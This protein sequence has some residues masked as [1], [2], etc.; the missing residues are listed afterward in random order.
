VGDTYYVLGNNGYLPGVEAYPKA[1]EAALKALELDESLAEAHASLAA[2]RAEYDRDWSAGEREY[3]RAIG[4]NPSYATAHAWYAW[5]LAV[6]GR[7][8]EAIR[9]IELARR[10]DPLSPR[11]SA[12]VGL[13]LY[14]ARQY[15]RAIAE[16]LK[17]VELEPGNVAA[18]LYL[19]STYLQ[20]GINGEALSEA[21]KAASLWH[22]PRALFS[23]A[24]VYAVTGKRD[25][26]LKKLGDL[27]E[28]SKR[29]HVSPYLIAIVSVALGHTNEAFA[30]LQKGLDDHDG[31]MGEMKVEPA[32]DPLR[33]DP[34]FQDILRRMNFPP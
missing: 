25:Q 1:R 21:Q 20:K 11:I 17:A 29:E 22:D 24:R 26:A 16:L 13:V 23:F 32:L 12:N 30:W 14:F 3:Q 28:L 6:T 31:P 33:S 18:H 10:L 9:E 19:S 15:D 5:N 7:D 4:L 8:S 27:E 34:R 2:A